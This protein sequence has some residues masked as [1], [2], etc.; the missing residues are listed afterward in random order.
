MAKTQKKAKTHLFEA[1]RGS[2]LNKK[3]IEQ[4]KNWSLAVKVERMKQKNWWNILQ[5]CKCE[6]HVKYVKYVNIL[7]FEVIYSSLNSC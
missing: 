7:V 5:K 2:F 4:Q 6:K 1:A 3:K